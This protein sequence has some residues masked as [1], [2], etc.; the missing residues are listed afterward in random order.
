MKQ[1]RAANIDEI[2]FIA[3]QLFNNNTDFEPETTK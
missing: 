3:D 2:H 1:I